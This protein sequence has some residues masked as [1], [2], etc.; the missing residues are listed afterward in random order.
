MAD[1]ARS[2]LQRT[3]DEITGYSRRTRKIIWGLVIS[4]V[5]DVALTVVIGFLTASALHANSTLHESQL[6]ACALTN[7]SRAEN[8]GLWDYL[9]HLAGGAKTPAD[10]L[11]LA[12]VDKTFAPEDCAA[13]YK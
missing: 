9:F 1:D 5:L 11:L 13:I 10:K 6:N 4:I 12:R 8:L 2:S 7:Q 3:V